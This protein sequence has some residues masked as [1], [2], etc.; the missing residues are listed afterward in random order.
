MGDKS[1]PGLLTRI[2]SVGI[3]DDATSDQPSF[4][5]LH[6]TVSPPVCWDK[7]ALEESL[8]V[9]L[10]QEMEELWNNASSLRL[11]E[12][13][14]YGQWGL[15]IWAPD[16]TIA[17]QR[18]II[19]EPRLQQDLRTG[20]LIIGEFRGDLEMPVL[21]CDPESEDF[22]HV[23]IAAEI[24]KRAEWPDVGESLTEFLDRFL[25]S[26]EEKYWESNLSSGS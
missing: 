8:S 11:F 20:D 19:L 1:I 22:G 24:D 12:D 5:P 7:H 14:N 25:Q 9:T 3:I 15:I 4:R 21:R 16:Q 13:V 6:C 2:R 17:K 18:K 26:P 23:I 10:P